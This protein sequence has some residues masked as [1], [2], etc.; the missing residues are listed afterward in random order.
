[1]DGRKFCCLVCF[2]VFSCRF[3]Q[4]PHFLLITPGVLYFS[5]TQS[6]GIY[7]LLFLS[8]VFSGFHLSFLCAQCYRI[9]SSVH[10]LMVSCYLY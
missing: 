8:P 10:C 9:L 7:P 4:T 1:M 5:L 6:E 2:F 3:L